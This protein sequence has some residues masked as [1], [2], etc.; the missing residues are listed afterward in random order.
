MVL[1]TTWINMFG[2]KL[3][4]EVKTPF[5]KHKFA[6]FSLRKFYLRKKYK[7]EVRKRILL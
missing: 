2:F 3:P 5:R 4:P 6:I 7:P 1:K